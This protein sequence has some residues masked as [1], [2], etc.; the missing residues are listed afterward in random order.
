MKILFYTSR[1]SKIVFG[2]RQAKTS[3]RESKREE[4]AAHGELRQYKTGSFISH[5]KTSADGRAA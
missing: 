1:C 3:Y 4:D 5:L 2:K